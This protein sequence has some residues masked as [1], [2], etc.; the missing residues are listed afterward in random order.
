MLS[1][2]KDIPRL[3]HIVYCAIAQ[4]RVK[5]LLLQ[6]KEHDEY[7]FLHSIN[8]GVLALDFGFYLNLDMTFLQNLF[9]AGILHDIGKLNI[10]SELLNKKEPLT[11]TEFAQIRCHPEDGYMI[12][13]NHLFNRNILCGIR[14]HHE[15]KDG[16]GYP[17]GIQEISQT[18]S[19]IKIA[20]AYDAMK[21]NRVYC[22]SMTKD[23]IQ[24]EL[25]QDTGMMDTEYKCIFLNKFL[26]AIC[27]D[28]MHK[29]Q[30]HSLKQ[31]I[32]AEL[33]HKDTAMASN[34]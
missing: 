18:G 3:Q 34:L 7:T 32:L 16:T 26:P 29:E 24:E 12:A 15:R 20:D 8:V 28:D 13:K 19:I 31:F 9:L 33:E 1:I 10:P 14:E 22:S 25:F 11:D 21:A 17:L 4:N 30:M 6:L 5:K 2:T 23:M 27:N